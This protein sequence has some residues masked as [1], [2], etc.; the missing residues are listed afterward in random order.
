M[1]THKVTEQEVKHPK[2]W[3]SGFSEKSVDLVVVV[4]PS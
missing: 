2:F 3:T 1:H 4:P